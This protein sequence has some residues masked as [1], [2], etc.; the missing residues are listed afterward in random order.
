MKKALK[1]IIRVTGALV[2]M[3]DRIFGDI[4]G[5]SGD[6]SG[7]YGNISSGLY[8]NISSGLSGDISSGLSGDISGLYGDIGGLYGDIDECD[9]SDE[10]RGAGIDVSDLIGD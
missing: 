10:E 1:K 2:G 8:G 6:I 7:L 4:G 5:L 3:H 9:I